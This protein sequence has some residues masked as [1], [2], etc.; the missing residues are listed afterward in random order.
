MLNLPSLPLD[1]KEPDGTTVKLKR[2]KYGRWT[3]AIMDDGI[4]VDMFMPEE[5]PVTLLIN[6]SLAYPH[7]SYTPPGE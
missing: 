4:I 1:N 5:D 6:V 3:A 7:V 2:D